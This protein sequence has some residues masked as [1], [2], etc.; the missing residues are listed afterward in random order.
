MAAKAD[1]L[2][3]EAER[4]RGGAVGPIEYDRPYRIFWNR[5]GEAFEFPAD[6]AQFMLL[7]E[8][9]W[10]VQKPRKPEPKPRFQVMRDGSHYEF[11]GTAQ[12]VSEVERARMNKTPSSPAATQPTATYYTKD[13]N[14]LHNLP[15]D[16]QSMSEYLAAGLTLDPPNKATGEV[17]QL[18]VASSR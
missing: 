7:I 14:P 1:P 3:R 9:G 16:P 10:L 13:G 6:P 18:K 4:G 12:D 17:V 15:A 2:L 5:Y 11:S 8:Q